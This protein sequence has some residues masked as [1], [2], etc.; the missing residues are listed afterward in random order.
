MARSDLVRIMSTG[1]Y[2]AFKLFE[3]ENLKEPGF[4]SSIKLCSKEYL[5]LTK[6][7]IYPLPDVELEAAWV[8]H[9]YLANTKYGL[10]AHW[11]AD[12]RENIDKNNL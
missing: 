7:K 4:L 2:S 1:E 5:P 9:N 8:W 12:N 11:V 6:H 3:T 10:I